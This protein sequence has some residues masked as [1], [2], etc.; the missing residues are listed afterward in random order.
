MIGNPDVVTIVHEA[1]GL[2]RACGERFR[3]GPPGTRDRE[4]ECSHPLA[5]GC[6]I[7]RDR[8][9]GDGCR[10]NCRGPGAYR[11]QE[12]ERNVRASRRDG[13]RARRQSLV[14]R[15]SRLDQTL[16]A[17]PEHSLKPVATQSE[18]R[19]NETRGIVGSLLELCGCQSERRRAFRF[20]TVFGRGIRSLAALGL[21][22]QGRCGVCL[23]SLFQRCF[24]VFLFDFHVL[25]CL[26]CLFCFVLDHGR[27][28]PTK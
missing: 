18:Q 27:C 16:L 15:V 22:R 21:R 14:R 23:F 4:V 9:G 26:F 28:M 2:H 17:E 6:R 8:V 24:V 20:A 12:P 3:R 13:D 11:K 5:H 7:G 1:L 10:T 19:N 25:F